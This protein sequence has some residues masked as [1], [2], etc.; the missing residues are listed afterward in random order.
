MPVFNNMLAGASG[1]A[2]AAGYEIERSLRFNK[3]DG[4]ELLKTPSSAGNRRTFTHSFWVKRSSAGSQRTIFSAN[5]SS[6]FSSGWQITIEDA[7]TLSV[8]GSSPTFN[9]TT[10]QVLRDQ[11]AWYHIVIATDTTQSTASNRQKIYINGEPV[12]TFGTS[13]YPSQNDELNCNGAFVHQISGL[14]YTSSVDFDGYLA[15]V[16]FIDGQA[17]APTD[18][19]ETDDNGVWQPKEASF[20]SPNNGTTWSNSGSGTLANGNWGQA[21]D[22]TR[23]MYGGSGAS[24]GPAAENGTITFSPS[25]LSGRV[26]T[27]GVRG[28]G[29]KDYTVNDQSMTFGSTNAEVATIDLGSTQSITSIKAIST[30]SGTWAQFYWIA[31]DGVLLVD[32]AGTYGTNGFH[33]PFSDNSSSAALGTDTSGNSNTWTVN[34]IAASAPGLATANQGFDV[35]AYTGTG[36]AQAITGLSFQPDFV[37][38]KQRSGTYDHAIFDSVRGA[39]KRLRANQTNAEGTD[40]T[41][42][43]SFNANGFTTGSDDVTNKNSSTY[44][45]WC[46]KAG[47]A[48]SSNTDGTITSQVSAST[49]YGFSIVS[50]TGAGSG[51]SSIGHGL[52]TAPSW[53]ILK[54]RSATSN[55]SVYHSSVGNTKRLLLN[56]SAAEAAGSTFWNNTSPTSSVFSVGGDLNDSATKIA[57]C[58]SEVAGFSKFGSYTGTGSSAQT[59]ECGFSPAYV[60]LK[61]STGVADW[62]IF[63]K[64]RG[65]NNFL[66]ANTSVADNNI[67]ASLSFTSTGFTVQN[68][69][70]TNGSGDTFIYAAFADRP[71][72][73]WTPNNLSAGIPNARPYASQFVSSTGFKASYPAIKAFDDS[74]STYAQASTSGGTLTFTPST[75]ISYSSS[76]KIWMPSAGATASIN[77]GSSV[78]VANSSEATIATGSGTLTS[79]VLAASNLPGLAYIKID[80]QI[81]I[82]SGL[83]TGNDSLVDSPSNGTQDDTGIGGEVVGNYATLNPLQSNATGPLAN[84]NLEWGGT[85]AGNFQS[86]VATIGMPSGKWYAEFT[87]SGGATDT[88]CGI[89]RLANSYALVTTGW[90]IGGPATSYGYYASSGNKINTGAGSSYG[91]AYADGDTIGVAF[92][93]DNGTLTFYKNGVSQGTAFTGLT[94]TFAFGCSTYATTKWIAN[95]GQRSFAYTAPSGYKSLNTANLPEPTIAD[96]SKYFDT[97]LYIGN[98]GTQTISGFNFAPDWVWIKSRSSAAAHCTADIVVGANKHLLPNET[99]AE[100][101][102]LVTAFTSDGFTVNN[103][104]NGADNG[105]TNDN[106]FSYVSWVWDGGTSTVTNNDGSIAS[107]V[108]ANPSAGFSIVS[109]NSGSSTGNYTLGHGLN[110]APQFIIHKSRASGNW[111]AYHASVIDDTSKYLQLNSG[112]AIATNSAPMWGAALP[113]S[114]VFGVRVGD[115]IGTNTDTI[116][117]C[118][119]PVAGYS[120]MGSYTGNGSTDGPCIALS[121]RPAF[122]LIKNINGTDRWTIQDTSRSTFNASTDTLAPNLSNAELASAFDLDFLSNG[123]KVRSTNSGHNSSGSTYIWY[124]VAENPFQANGGLAR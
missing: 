57:Y 61:N 96:G 50:W 79:L 10:S 58:W 108:R 21:F 80:D 63:D 98:D 123:F 15:D 47:G 37:W 109:Y 116:A 34:N 67:G 89:T 106:N 38:I 95:F 124:A 12:T 39:L 68:W 75:G 77:G 33:L 5:T 27:A 122:V 111:W 70:T 112:S 119:A 117:Y 4:S 73:N 53:I 54:N 104:R 65:D 91:A 48:A 87:L 102:G 76:I 82:D 99:A 8:N 52:S 19:G 1:G 2:G 85:N 86:S 84:G 42:L 51:N 43:T 74:T 118:F 66:I 113:T 105:T 94:G 72:N 17:L 90:F 45:A 11:S 83:D 81:L 20:T 14:G 69:S 25:G 18:F 36:S 41:T 114:S 44:V 35:V 22:G 93:A 115:L 23:Y 55:W 46:W 78:S 107:Q 92:D 103:L 9:L 59:I 31:V 60:I 29:N 28:G 56:S 16:H 120:A 121:F 88:T 26:I 40:T 62:A 30:A 7:D 32:G 3:G 13:N 110:S 100:A 49:D 101:T 24:N 6:N 97:K 64:A 71:G